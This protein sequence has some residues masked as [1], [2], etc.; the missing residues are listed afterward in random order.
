MCYSQ[1]FNYNGVI[2]FYSR[3]MNQ[4]IYIILCYEL[5]LIEHT[6]TYGKEFVNFVMMHLK[7]NDIIGS[8]TRANPEFRKIFTTNFKPMS[9][10]VCILLFKSACVHCAV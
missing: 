5:I 2:Q 1:R 4:Y 10:I 7:L 9:S 3:N 6:I 8:N